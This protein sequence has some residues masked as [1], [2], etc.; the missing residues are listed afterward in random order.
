M[1][2]NPETVD[3][4]ELTKEGRDDRGKVSK[5]TDSEEEIIS[6][7]LYDTHCRHTHRKRLGK[8][9]IST[10]TPMAGHLRKTKGI[11]QRK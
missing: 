6:G 1:T 11:T 5:K 4:R 2:D 9:N 8:R 3:E 7:H 10:N